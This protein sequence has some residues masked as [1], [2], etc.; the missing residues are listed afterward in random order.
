MIRRLALLG[1]VLPWVAWAQIP[2]PL[3]GNAEEAFGGAAIGTASDKD[4]LTKERKRLQEQQR[5]LGLRA[6]DERTW[7]DRQTT[8]AEKREALL[9]QRAELV[10]EAPPT[11]EERV[12][13]AAPETPPPE[14]PGTGEAPAA[15]DSDAAPPS[16]GKDAPPSAGNDAPPTAPGDAPPSVPEAAPETEPPVVLLPLL[17]LTD[18]DGLKEAWLAPGIHPEEVRAI[19]EIV[20]LTDALRRRFDLL[21]HH[22]RE[23]RAQLAQ[24]LLAVTSLIESME[25][26][27]EEKPPPEGFWSLQDVERQARMASQARQAVMLARQRAQQDR[28]LDALEEDDGELEE[29]RRGRLIRYEPQAAFLESIARTRTLRE[30]VSRLRRELT[31]LRP[32]LLN[33]RRQAHTARTAWHGVEL[34]TAE[35]TADDLD[36]QWRKALAALRISP[37]DVEEYQKRLDEARA[38]RKAAVEKIQQ[39]IDELP[40]GEELEDS[41]EESLSVGRLYRMERVLLTE[42]LAA[43][44]MRVERAEFRHAVAVHLGAVIDGEPPPTELNR[45]AEALSPQANEA[46][47][48]DLD[49]R[50]DGWRDARARAE[51][52][53]A[54]EADQE[55]R[56]TR[57]LTIYSELADLCLSEGRTLA[58]EARTAAI[59][60]YHLDR[61]VRRS[62][63]VGWYALRVLIS[64]VLVFVLLYATRWIGRVTHRLARPPA[65]P[66]QAGTPPARGE[67]KPGWAGRWERIR[68]NLA[69]LIYLGSASALWFFAAALTAQHVW[70]LPVEWSSWLAWMTHPLLTVADNPVS[71]FSILSIGVWFV[72]A[73][74]LSRL[75][76]TFLADGLMEHFAVD[77]GLRDVVGTLARYLVVLLGIIFG[78]SAAGIPLTAMAAIFG[79]LGIG[80]GFGLQNI[81]SNFI[82]GFIILLER[83]YR[84]GDFIQVGDMVGEVK[85]IRARATTIETRDAVTVVVP[86]SEFVVGRVVNWT[87]GQSERLRAQVRVGVAYGT[88]LGLATRALLDVARQHPDVLSWPPPRA[89]MS[90][91][92]PSNIDLV[93]HIWTRRLRTLP[94]LLS[95]LYMAVD[96][97]FRQDGIEIPF[98]IQTVHLKDAPNR[99]AAPPAVAPPTAPPGPGTTPP[100]AP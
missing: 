48:A 40:P 59:A 31:G 47:K 70:S 77:Q 42:R 73:I 5:D 14:A 34:R 39:A 90:G 9:D 69:L 91:F 96:Q 65:Q 75:F 1:V 87:L 78:L 93:L 52:R 72:G 8:L 45:Y 83:P 10:R 2:V 12:W 17:E 92:G 44:R 88:D 35:R 49:L 71:L 7:Q 29:R 36:Q 23:E 33:A 19:D 55:K 95:D 43:E 53:A 37:T 27:A 32:P 67:V 98:P 21:L 20:D 28:E 46:R 4:A 16:A 57:L 61:Q 18:E 82:S 63:T 97:R 6:Q 11:D 38:Q 24:A 94:G 54:L 85:E 66:E 26:P 60:R 89:E 56:R 50:C 41:G 25:N 22:H 79:V 99:T 80:I 68:G 76:Q 51:S 3:G 62:R 13:D 81:A 15:P 64:A 58:S 100:T 74:W 86:N 84:R 30:E